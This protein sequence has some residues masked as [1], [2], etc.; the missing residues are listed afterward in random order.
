MPGSGYKCSAFVF[1]LALFAALLPARGRGCTCSGPPDTIS[2]LLGSDAVFEGVVLST[3]TDT[4]ILQPRFGT[5]THHFTVATLKVLRAWKGV[6]AGEITVATWSDGASCGFPLRPG[7]QYLLFAHRFNGRLVTD[8]C[9]RSAPS[10]SA[11]GEF[12]NL[13]RPRWR[14]GP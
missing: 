5:I 14:P 6:A 3:T 12:R 1:A 11:H 7:G 13:G 9:S 10:A 4:L 8:I 2:A